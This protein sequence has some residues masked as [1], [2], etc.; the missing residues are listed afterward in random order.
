MARPV[1]A[2]QAAAQG[3][4]HAGTIRVG[5]SVSEIIDCVLWALSNTAEAEEM[6]RDARARVRSRYHWQTCLAELDMP[7]PKRNLPRGG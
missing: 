6:A 1:V 7:L 5:S 3:I 2:S 4:D